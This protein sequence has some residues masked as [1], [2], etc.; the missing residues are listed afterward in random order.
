MP[1]TRRGI[2]KNGKC[3]TGQQFVSVVKSGLRAVCGHRKCY[4]WDSLCTGFLLG[5]LLSCS[6][7]T[8]FGHFSLV[9]NQPINPWTDLAEIFDCVTQET[10]RP[11]Y[12]VAAGLKRGWCFPMF[13][14]SD[15]CT[16][17]SFNPRMDFAQWTQKNEF[18]R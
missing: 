1:E 14:S 18:W 5:G 6:E 11:K 16:T 8:P 9:I 17:H 3:V 4:H 13:G 12:M 10:S 7:D 15:A 2:N